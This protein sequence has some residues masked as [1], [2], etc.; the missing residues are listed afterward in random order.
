MGTENRS[1]NE[2]MKLT[3]ISTTP[4]NILRELAKDNEWVIRYNVAKHPNT[5]KD[6][7]RQLAKD[8]DEGVRRHVA[9]NPNTSEKVLRNLAKD[10]YWY[11]RRT[12]AENPNVSITVLIMLFEYENNCKKPAETILQALYKNPKLPYV[13]KVIIETLYGEML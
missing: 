10:K 2:K 4:E 13:A 7:L 9:E 11:V 5:P 12:L 8:T 3:Y 1:F 6:L